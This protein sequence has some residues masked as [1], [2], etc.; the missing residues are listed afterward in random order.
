[1]T[2]DVRA[3]RGRMTGDGA[4]SSSRA[5]RTVA[6]GTAGVIAS[7]VGAGVLGRRAVARSGER[8]RIEQQ[9]AALARALTERAR[10]AVERESRTARD[11]R[12][13]RGGG[14]LALVVVGAA[15]AGAVTLQQRRRTAID[16]DDLWLPEQTVGPA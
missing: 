15:V 4:P 5:V 14:A 6:L 3:L 8:R 11:G 16:P 1:V 9:A 2:D 13:R 10:G 12:S 7:V